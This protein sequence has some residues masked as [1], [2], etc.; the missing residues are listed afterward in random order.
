MLTSRDALEGLPG[1]RQEWRIPKMS[2]TMQEASERNKVHIFNVGAKQWIQYMGGLGT[3]VIAA[4][5]EGKRYSKPCIVPGIIAETNKKDGEIVRMPEEE[6]AA[7][8]LD[9]IGQ[10]P[11]KNQSQDLTKYGVFIAKGSTPTE[12]ELEAA[13]EKRDAYYSGLIQEADSAFE[14]NGGMETNNG[15]T[16]SNIQRHHI[17][18]AKAMNVDRPWRKVQRRMD[19]CP[20]CG[21]MVIPGAARCNNTGC[22]AILNEEKARKLFP[23]LFAAEPE[24]RGPGRPRNDA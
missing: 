22:G 3:F 10:G 5:E 19:N 21:G 11:F 4:C 20:E 9:I 13:E 17:D 12:E 16:Q 24:R 14:V 1:R 15:H 23:H 8:A 6:G 7:V 18:A 2:K